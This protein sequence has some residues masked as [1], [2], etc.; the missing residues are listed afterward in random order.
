MYK[1]TRHDR[2]EPQCGLDGFAQE[3]LLAGFAR[4]LRKFAMLDG[5]TGRFRLSV[6]I[7]IVKEIKDGLRAV[8]NGGATLDASAVRFIIAT[9]QLTPPKK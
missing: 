4:R 8:M 7:H 5:S 9:I 6:E 2:L 1:L 3:L